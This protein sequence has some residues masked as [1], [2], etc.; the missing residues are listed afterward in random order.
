[1]RI[2][3]IGYSVIEH[4]QALKVSAKGSLKGRREKN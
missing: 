4:P 1:M 3:S 2:G